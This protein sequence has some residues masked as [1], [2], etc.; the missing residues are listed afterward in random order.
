MAGGVGA[1]GVGA[2]PQWLEVLLRAAHPAPGLRAALS[3]AFQDE[4]SSHECNQRTV[5][6]Y[7]VG[8]EREE[9]RHQ[10]KKITKDIL[11]ILNKKSTAETGGKASGTAPWAV[12]P[13][14]LF[15]A[16]IR[17]LR[18]PVSSVLPLADDCHIEI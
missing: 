16:F 6:L 4:S 8:K 12:V 18:V 7:G 14:P 11:R 9:A 17:V 3:P 1:H 2:S 15:A 13:A 10:L 5:L